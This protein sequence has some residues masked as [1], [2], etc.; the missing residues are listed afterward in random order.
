MALRFSM[1]ILNAQV[2]FGQ[3]VALTTSLC[4]K[5]VPALKIGTLRRV[6][7]LRI[8]VYRLEFEYTGQNMS[9]WVIIRV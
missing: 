9:I 3:V 8:G 5:Q 6:R 4:I 2:M 7:K 1:L